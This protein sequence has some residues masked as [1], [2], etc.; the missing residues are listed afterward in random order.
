MDPTPIVLGVLGFVT[1]LATIITGYRQHRG[2]QAAERA[3]IDASL[4]AE[5]TDG[6]YRLV[7]QLQEQLNTEA[8]ARVTDR[9]TIDDL[10]KE[11]AGLQVK[12]AEMQVGITRLIG[13]LEAHDIEPVWRP[14]F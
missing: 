8:A 11:L 13:Q 10:R 6:I 5:R 2:T 7:D 4:V 3:K 14:H 12:M 9:A 1:T